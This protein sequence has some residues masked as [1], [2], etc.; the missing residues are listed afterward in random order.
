MIFYKKFT[1]LSS[2]QQCPR[3]TFFLRPHWH[4]RLY[5]LLVF[6]WVFVFCPL[7]CYFPDSSWGSAPFP[8]SLHYFIFYCNKLIHILC[9][10][11][12]RLFIFLLVI[13]SCSL[14]NPDIN[15][16]N[17]A[18][19]FSPLY[20]LPLNGFCYLFSFF[21]VGSFIFNE[22]NLSIHQS[23]PLLLLGFLS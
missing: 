14:F 23:F 15:I 7:I 2:H 9:L 11:S 21:S 22:A 19:L 1:Y 10:F 13:C 3:T 20:Y 6:E 8:I 16:I 17:I 18:N 12:V 5:C 4:K